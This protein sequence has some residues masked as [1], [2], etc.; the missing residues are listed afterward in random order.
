MDAQHSETDPFIYNLYFE[1]L[2]NFIKNSDVFCYGCHY[3]KSSNVFLK[4]IQFINAK[5]NFYITKDVFFKFMNNKSVLF[6]SPFAELFELQYKSGK[7]TIINPEFS[8]LQNALFYTNIYTFFNNGPHNNILETTDIIYNDILKNVHEHYDA[9]IISCGA[10]SNLL[11]NLFHKKNKDVLTI[12][13]DI[14][15]YFGILNNRRKKGIDITSFDKNV[16][17]TEIPDKYKPTDY[18]KIENGCYW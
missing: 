11:A 6:I 10:Y 8:T 1:T 4:L 16:W 15:F 3:D 7:C 17:I 5:N 2:L 13:G 12:G 18:M 9:V 14:Q